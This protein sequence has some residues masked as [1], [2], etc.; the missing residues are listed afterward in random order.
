MVRLAFSI[1]V[2]L[3]SIASPSIAQTTW[4]YKQ[5]PS[6]QPWRGSP[7]SGT[8]IGQTYRKTYQRCYVTR[9][10]GYK[11]WNHYFYGWC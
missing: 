1:T 11:C 5:P 8:Y 7:G 3:L 2:I 10:D 6:Y 9:C 4:Q